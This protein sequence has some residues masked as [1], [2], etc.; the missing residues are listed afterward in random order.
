MVDVWFAKQGATES[1]PAIGDLLAADT[2]NLLG[3]G[4]A[5]HE[6]TRPAAST[7]AVTGVSRQTGMSD[8]ELLRQQQP[9]L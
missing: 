4:A 8:E 1:L 9:L 2:G 3:G 6:T 7:A 5:G